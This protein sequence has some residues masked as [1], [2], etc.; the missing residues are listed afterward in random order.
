MKRLT[1]TVA[2]LVVLV[3]PALCAD[4][5]VGTWRIES[6]VREVTATGQRDNEFGDKPSGYI[7]Y[8]PDGRMRAMLVTGN[9]TKP[10]GGVPTD[11]EKSELFG[12]MIAYAGTY[13][14]D[15]DMVV[16]NVEVSWNQLWTGSKQVRFFKAEGDTLTI[17]TAVAKSPRDGQ[18]GRTIVVFKK[19]P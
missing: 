11:K 4:T 13:S 7:S 17:T 18:E 15:G 6:F 16:H 19:A 10:T 3:S 2:W 8:L 14:V 1:A 12:T 9:R 5:I